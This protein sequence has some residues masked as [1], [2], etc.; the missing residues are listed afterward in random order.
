MMLTVIGNTGSFPGPNSPASCYLLTGED[1]QGRTWR[2][3]LDM[4]NGSLGVLQR[5]VELEDIDAVMISHLHPD[6][7]VDLAGL[8]VAVKWDP[9]GWKA[10]RIPLYGPSGLHD[11]LNRSHAMPDGHSMETEFVFNVWRER[12]PVTV[13]PFTVTPFEVEHPCPES[14]ALRI[15]FDG[16]MGPSVMAYSGDTDSCDGLVDAARDAD[17]FLCEAAYEEGRED[18]LRGIHLTGYRAGQAA[19]QAKVRQLL[20]THLPVWNSPTRTRREAI[21]AFDGP[22]GIAEPGYTYKVV[23]ENV[24]ISGALARPIT[25]D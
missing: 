2:V 17:L 10:G 18:H 14:Y 7:C 20:L 9:R 6:H 15:T 3:I 22:V 8:H 4:G 13:G 5:Q 11:Y 21:A 25:A 23:S 24:T 16:P 1:H 19:A 12:Q